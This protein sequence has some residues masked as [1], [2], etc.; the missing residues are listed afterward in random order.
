MKK[1]KKKVRPP[2][3][4]QNLKLLGSALGFHKGA[5]RGLYPDKA[6]ID[7][8]EVLFKNYMVYSDSLRNPA[9][10][11]SKAGLYDTPCTEASTDYAYVAAGLKEG[12]IKQPYKTPIAFE[13]PYK[14]MNG[15]LYVYFADDNCKLVDVGDVKTC[16]D[17]VRQLG[18]K[19][20]HIVMINAKKIDNG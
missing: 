9:I 13:K 11:D 12:S 20:D 17:V 10:A 16:A 7:G 19:D 6:G 5:K 15:K 4:V 2:K 8:I 3:T 1:Y 18:F 14:G